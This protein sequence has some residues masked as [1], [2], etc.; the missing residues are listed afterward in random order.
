MGIGRERSGVIW[1]VC[2]AKAP[3]TAAGQ[4]AMLGRKRS[5]DALFWSLVMK[6]RIRMV[7]A[8]VWIGK[9]IDNAKLIRPITIVSMGG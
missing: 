1:V 3:T 8:S 6:D 4:M 5:K 7:R 9:I 2:D